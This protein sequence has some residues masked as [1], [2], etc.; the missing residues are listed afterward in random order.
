MRI[1][2]QEAQGDDKKIK[3]VEKKLRKAPFY[4]EMLIIKDQRRSDLPDS[5]FKF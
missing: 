1:T 5:F 2:S 4:Q 3:A